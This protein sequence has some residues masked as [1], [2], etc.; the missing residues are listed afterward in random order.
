MLTTDPVP[1]R[2]LNPSIPHDLE[3]ICLKCLEKEPA[4]RYASA[5]ALADELGCFL[6][7]EPIR[8]RPVGAPEKLWRWCRRK[9]ALAASLVALIF[10]FVSGFAGV[11]WQFAGKQRAFTQT[12]YNLYAARMNLAWSKW[13]SGSLTEARDLLESLR[14]QPGEEDL[15]GFEWRYL[16]PRC[17]S[18]EIFSLAGHQAYVQSVAISPDGTTLASGSGDQT[19][20]LWDVATR[21][22]LATLRGHTS[23][24]RSVV[25]FPDGKRLLSVSHLGGVS[26]N[27]RIWNL[28]TRTEAV[29]AIAF[30]ANAER[31][32][33]SR[34]GRYFAVAAYNAP[35]VKLWETDSLHELAS[36]PVMAYVRGCVAFSPD[37][38]LLAYGSGDKT[39][40]V[41]DVAGGRELGVLGEHEDQPSALCFSPDD[42]MLATGSFQGTVRLW[43]IAGGRGLATFR[44]HEAVVTSVEFSP[45]G[46]SLASAGADATLRLWE[47]KSQRA[48]RP[49]KGHDGFVNN[50]VFFPDGKRLA[51]SSD[52]LTVKVW[53]LPSP[54]E[55]RLSAGATNVVVGD[56]Q[57]FTSGFYRTRIG[58]RGGWRLSPNG[59][60]FASY[61][62]DRFELW[63]LPRSRQ[64]TP[65]ELTNQLVISA[66]FS[67]DSKWLASLGHTD[68]AAHTRNLRLWDLDQER[69][70]TSV[71]TDKA[72]ENPILFSPDG[73]FL[74]CGGADNTVRLFDLPALR[75]AGDLGNSSND[76]HYPL[77]FPPGGKT[78]ITQKGT[79]AVCV[80]DLARRGELLNISTTSRGFMRRI[81]SPDGKYMAT[82]EQATE[83]PHFDELVVRLW[84]LTDGR[85]VA[86]L[87]GHTQW[88]Q[89]LAFSP[90]S[91]WLATGGADSTIKL[92]DVR[93]Q[94][95][96]TTF[97]GHLGW[98]AD[99]AFSPDGRTLASSGS[100]GKLKLWNLAIQ[101][102]VG[103]LPG[104]VAPNTL[105]SFT[106]DGTAI[107]AL[108]EDRQFRIW[109][110]ADDK[111]SARANEA[112]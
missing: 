33:I 7:D 86:T 91:A 97:R 99:V 32:A 51:S 31:A 11:L 75:P 68:P 90:D 42:R 112:E 67:G 92:W 69:L 23:F 37:G 106:G 83:P 105:L 6:R 82:V 29:A 79:R 71:P 61:G 59:K 1:P 25:F 3:T 62:P 56:W 85:L 17:R 60:Y 20:K 80:W 38:N 5:Q 9:P 2:L 40:R 57:P 98:V 18:E 14:P 73:R 70:L 4:R 74:A 52:D 64:S 63:D 93:R 41:W 35:F 77:L 100:D 72:V 84:D 94:R 96:K 47:V 104:Q 26:R 13:E 48:R 81:V 54:I 87:S 10:V 53:T 15:R 36:I 88:I 8:A 109:R 95:L 58:L 30:G 102:D 22:E 45:D 44:G 101:Q 66:A 43:D 110:I 12:R 108:G 107:I 89:A 49:L 24:V 27:I 28:E 76:L 39:V 19:I 21:R 34:D 78:L 46:E 16:R 103:A 55:D 65:W 50:I 111:A